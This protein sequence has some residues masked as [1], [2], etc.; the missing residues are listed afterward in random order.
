MAGKNASH[1][2]FFN[3][4]LEEVKSERSILPEQDR[5]RKLSFRQSYFTELSAID[6]FLN[7]EVLA[8]IAKL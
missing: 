5:T 8:V 3:N 4:S 6:S 7:P 1:L 2:C